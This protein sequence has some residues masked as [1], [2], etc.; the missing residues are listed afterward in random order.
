MKKTFFVIALFCVGLASFAQ[1]IRFTEGSLNDALKQ[2]AEQNK[3]VFVDFYASWCGP[4]KMM[5]QH[6]FP[7]AEVGGYFNEKFVNYQLDTEAPE[8][9]ELMEKYGIRNLPTLMVLN[10]AGE[11]VAV[12]MGAMD[13]YG[14]LRFGKTALGEQPSANDLYKAYEKDKKNPET[15]KA[16]LMDAPFF[17]QGIEGESQQKRW[18]LR[19]T[20]LF[21]SY[22]DTKG[23]DNMTNADDFRILSTY[24]VKMGEND[25]IVEPMVKYYNEFAKAIDPGMLSNYITQLHMQ[26]IHEM[27]RAGNKRYERE[28]G[29]I[30]GDMANVYMPL[31]PD[32]EGFHET[33]KNF[34]DGIYYIF[35]E[36][37]SEKYIESTERY[38]SLLP[39]LTYNDYAS[40]IENLINGLDEK[41]DKPAAEK[42]LEWIAKA[43]E[44]EHNHES[45]VSMTMV[46]GDCYRALKDKDKARE[47]YNEAFSMLLKSQNQNFVMQMQQL[48]KGRLASVE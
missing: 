20:R 29:R 30:N 40:A 21:N 36:K 1:G 3:P 8:N 15:M 4:C 18:A 11:P 14:L 16:V 48:L 12:Q 23:V 25:K 17:M 28:V 19:I 7:L 13:G 43:R 35:H 31:Y 2:A 34:S 5:E 44:K 22:V 42:S 26:Y 41:P 45:A 27:A 37:N 38:L 9:K 39:D 33:Y 32:V 6:V 46:A 24:H 10:S 47:A